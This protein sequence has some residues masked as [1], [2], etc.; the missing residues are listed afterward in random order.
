MGFLPDTCTMSDA[1]VSFWLRPG[2]ACEQFWWSPG[3]RIKSHSLTA[4]CSPEYQSRQSSRVAD[5]S[6]I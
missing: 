4:F 3:E 1:F 2:A 6:G 5:R